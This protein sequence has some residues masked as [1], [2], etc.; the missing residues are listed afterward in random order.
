[1]CV[2]VRNL[3]ITIT[4]YLDLMTLKRIVFI[5][6]R[7]QIKNKNK[8]MGKENRSANTSIHYVQ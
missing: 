3:M 5:K 6:Q 1:M 2:D 8:K 4:H 7:I